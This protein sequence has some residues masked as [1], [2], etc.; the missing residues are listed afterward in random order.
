M[1]AIEDMRGGNDAG[2]TAREWAEQLGRSYEWT[3][4]QLNLLKSNGKL[5][6]G[7]RRA[8]NLSEHW[9]IYTVYRLRNRDRS[10]G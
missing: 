6:V 9:H 7:Q 2:L 4:Q 1:Q 10:Q 3:C 8:K 5:V